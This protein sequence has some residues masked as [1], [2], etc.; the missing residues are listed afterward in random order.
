MAIK[1]LTLMADFETTTDPDDCRVWA[2]GAVDIDKLEVAYIG[3]SIDG[4]MQ[5]LSDKQTKV[6]WHNLRF[7]GEFV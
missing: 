6:Y 1:T 3:T 7:D 2:G 5:W 4:F